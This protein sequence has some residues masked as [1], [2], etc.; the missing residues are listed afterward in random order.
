MLAFLVTQRSRE[1]GIRIAL[2]STDRA[3]FG[4][5][6]REGLLLVAGG[7]CLGIAGTLALRQVLQSRIYGLGAMSP[8][9][10]GTVMIVLALI[11]LMASVVPAR[12]ASRVD[13][14]TALNRQ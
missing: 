5:V 13:P 4:L 1:I 9:V 8:I 14:V 10:M 12:R 6:V 11:A 7:L 3:I 2:G